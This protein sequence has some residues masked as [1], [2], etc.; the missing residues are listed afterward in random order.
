MDIINHCMSSRIV[1][2]RIGAKS[3]EGKGGWEV[4]NERRPRLTAHGGS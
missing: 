1:L 4:I 3:V 2:N